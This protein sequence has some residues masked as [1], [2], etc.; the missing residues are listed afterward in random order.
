LARL[1]SWTIV[2]LA[3]LGIASLVS[4]PLVAEK[5]AEQTDFARPEELPPKPQIP[6]E[7]E[8]PLVPV[9]ELHEALRLPRVD[10]TLTDEHSR[11]SLAAYRA[12][13]YERAFEEAVLALDPEPL[14]D[15]DLYRVLTSPS[16][17]DSKR[18]RKPNGRE[19]IEAVD[20]ALAPVLEANESQAARLNNAAAMMILREYTAGEAAQ[21]NGLQVAQELAYQAADLQPSCPTLMNLTLLNGAL[22]YLFDPADLEP[23]NNEMSSWSSYYT[24]E[25][26][27]DPALYYYL[28]QSYVREDKEYA[29]GVADALQT[30]PALAGLAHS[31]RGDIYYWEGVSA[32]EGDEGPFTIRHQFQ[33]AVQEYS[34]ALKLQPDDTAIRHGLAL[35][36]LELGGG[37]ERGQA[38]VETLDRATREAEAALKAEPDS[39][40]F[41]QTLA[42]IYEAQGNYASAARLYRELATTQETPD[43]SLALV[44]YSA[45]SHGADRYSELRVM[46]G[47]A[48]AAA[49]ALFDD[50][51]IEPYT[52]TFFVPN[53]KFEEWT[54]PSGLDEFRS[55]LRF[56][57]LLRADLLSGNAAAFEEDLQR[58]PEAVRRDEQTLLL[59]GI[60]RLPD[61]RGV[62]PSPEARTSMNEFVEKHSYYD[63]AAGEPDFQGD[64]LFYLEAGNLFRQYG[65]Y[66]SALRVYGAWQDDLERAKAG[67]KR[68]AEVQKLIGEVHSLQGDY[69][70]ALAAFERAASLRPNWPPYIVRQAFAHEK[71]EEYDTAAE[72]YRHALEVMQERTGWMDPDDL[73]YSSPIE[74]YSY[75]YSDPYEAAKHLGDM[76]LRQA[77]NYAA[78]RE[79][80]E[81]AEKIVAKFDEAAQAYRRALDVGGVQTTAAANN[82]G[83]AL[84]L[85]EKEKEEED[86]DGAI[87]VL[88][89]LVQP[90]DESS[91][92]WQSSVVPDE[93]NPIFHL[94]LG[95]TYELDGQ[96]EKA[97]EQYLAAVRGDPTFHPA[98]NDLGVLAAKSGELSDAQGYFDAAL[99][100]KPDY[101][102]AAYNLGVALLR[103]G[104]QNFL[105]AQHYLA[106]AV[107][108]NDSLSETSYDYVFDNE[109]Y[110][111]N[112]SL[113]TSVP[114]DWEFATHAE[115]STF[116]VSFGAVVL[117]L[118]GILLRTVRQKGRETFIGKVSEFLR[119][120]YGAGASRL[121]A[122][123]R[124][125]WLHLSGLGRPSAGRWWMTPLALLTTAL[126]VTLVQGWS[127]LWTHSAVK[128]V[129][130]AML[131]YVAFVSLLVHHAGHAVVALRSR[132]R[133]TDAPWPAGIAQAIV[134][135]AVGG[136]FVAPMPATS[137]EGKAEERRRQ[138]VLLAGPLATIFLAVLLYALYALSH[139][140]LFRF[141]V[142]LNLG[143]AAA[144]LLS[145]PPLEGATIGEG[146]YRRWTI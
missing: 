66:E 93:N 123:I 76:L 95:W 121:W 79:G 46:V 89:T 134:L 71:L 83:V 92:D 9:S 23:A 28:A 82:M 15:N 73:E 131:V 96:P 137:V 129:M 113:G 127:L 145:L 140:P 110:F 54:V 38:D 45:L 126:A 141:G 10:T 125:G 49:A 104:P 107:G 109:L 97:K 139:I 60:S 138:L 99:E 7:R 58:T 87:E 98:L 3:F 13:D 47:S 85:A 67:S 124:D 27:A 2:V 72:T 135:V 25:G 118:W 50:E 19:A 86:F 90:V 114:P 52:P 94:N 16:T 68:R 39:P 55:Q 21:P 111:L 41:R 32:R 18:V 132:L 143:L 75:H 142:V 120:R 14:E 30:E 84:L 53:V 40:R 133:V 88:R 115:R 36:Y 136:P 44:P 4:I 74:I 34:V 81:N 8:E 17:G 5:A 108:Q 42:E 102:Y 80:D 22:R 6:E 56:Y 101:D 117:L 106:R 69:G 1:V 59:V 24:A 100:A 146:Y 31:L 63:P 20:R 33:S 64:D 105:A 61:R 103:S 144:S 112:L 77:K 11:A 12:E 29:L 35:A 128:P 116:V 37:T 70:D 62:A 51:V 57:A 130:V 43:G 78:V 48:A 26:C 119:A 122:R 91:E 65:Q